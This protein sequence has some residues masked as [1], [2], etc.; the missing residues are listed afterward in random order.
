[1]DWRRA[2][3][4]IFDQLT[5][6]MSARPGDRGQLQYVVEVIRRAKRIRPGRILNVKYVGY[7]NLRV[8]VGRINH[9][10]SS[11]S[12][13]FPSIFD[14]PPTEPTF[15]THPSTQPSS[16]SPQ[17]YPASRFSSHISLN[18]HRIRNPRCRFVV[19]QH[20]KIPANRFPGLACVFFGFRCNHP[21][22]EKVCHRRKEA[23][24]GKNTDRDEPREQGVGR[25]FTLFLTRLDSWGLVGR[26]AG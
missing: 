1:M 13:F 3:F 21:S 16:T 24:R 4:D 9:A 25:H 15:Y 11:S 23:R 10:V 26:G 20:P 6:W 5:P 17:K 18:R 7:N 2:G 22:H 14:P 12:N 8:H 19:A